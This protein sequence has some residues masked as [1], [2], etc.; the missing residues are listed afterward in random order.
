MKYL[1]STLLFACLALTSCGGKQSSGENWR[2]NVFV[3]YLDV[4][5][6]TAKLSDAVSQDEETVWSAE[7]VDS[8][9]KKMQTNPDT[10]LS[11][12]LAACALAQ[13]Y[14]AYG[15]YYPWAIMAQVSGENLPYPVVN[16]E[17]YD[18]LMSAKDVSGKGV[19]QAV[20]DL[21]FQSLETLVNFMFAGAAVTGNQRLQQCAQEA[22]IDLQTT[23]SAAS[24]PESRY[25]ADAQA[26]AFYIKM[27]YLQQGWYTVMSN[28]ILSFVTDGAQWQNIENDIDDYG[29]WYK[30]Q[31]SDLAFQK[32][33][34]T[35]AQFYQFMV[36]STQ[37]KVKMLGMVQT[38][39]KSIKNSPE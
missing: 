20:A 30:D 17:A 14:Y 7:M 8:I 37:R 38:I 26:N 36:G 33:P 25:A 34:I 13:N 9:A 24:D 2:D 27:T 1:F 19:Y 23:R 31:V 35:Q 6:A 5:A 12:G 32:K 4:L 16:T 29:Q 39:L 22:L 21:D 11:H 15:L 3:P 18:K 28:L 10:C